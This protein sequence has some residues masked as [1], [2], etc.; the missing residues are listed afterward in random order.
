[1]FSNHAP[2]SDACWRL[3]EPYL[4]PRAP[5]SEMTGSDTLAFRGQIRLM[6]QTWT[7]MMTGVSGTLWRLPD[8]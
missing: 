3:D 6:V 4:R 7:I 1:M 5:T 2:Y 8:H